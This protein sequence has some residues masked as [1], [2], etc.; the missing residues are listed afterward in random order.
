[1]YR[2]HTIEERLNV[3]LRIINGEPFK[4]ICREYGLD[5][6]EVRQWLSNRNSTGGT[7]QTNGRFFGM[8]V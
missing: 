7:G 6:N 1:M 3:I 5:A 2:H 4:K 8:L